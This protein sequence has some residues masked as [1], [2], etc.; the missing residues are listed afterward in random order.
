MN[1]KEGIEIN[2][3]NDRNEPNDTNDLKYHKATDMLGK[4]F[5]NF[6]FLILLPVSLSVITAVIVNIIAVGLGSGLSL[7][8]LFTLIAPIVGFF[9]LPSEKYRDKKIVLR[10]DIINK[11]HY[12]HYFLISAFSILYS[13]ILTIVF[14]DPLS[15]SLLHP[16]FSI[17]SLIFYFKSRDLPDKNWSIKDIRNRKIEQILVISGISLRSVIVI[18]LANFTNE[19][20]YLLIP[21]IFVLVLDILGYITCIFIFNKK[22]NNE[23]EFE[24]NTSEKLSEKTKS[25][26]VG[27]SIPA[28]QII[29]LA[30][31]GL[32]FSVLNDP[33]PNITLL[34]FLPIIGFTFAVKS[35][36]FLIKYY[37]EMPSD[38]NILNKSSKIT[39]LSSI[40]SSA[41]LI[42]SMGLFIFE[43]FPN[44]NYLFSHFYVV[45]ILVISY[46][47][48]KKEM[49]QRKFLT[50]FITFS[51]VLFISMITFV[52][53]IP[54]DFF[55]LN[56]LIF[57]VLL[58]LDIEFLKRLKILTNQK[59]DLILAILSYLIIYEIVLTIT[60]IFSGLAFSGFNVALKWEFAF[61]FESYTLALLIGSIVSGL[62]LYYSNYKMKTN[63]RFKR[64]FL[65]LHSLLIINIVGLITFTIDSPHLLSVLI[66]GIVTLL[67]STILFYVYQKIG[68]Y[69]FPDY[70][71]L[72][73]YSF[74]IQTVLIGTSI[75]STNLNL[76]SFIGSSLLLTGEIILDQFVR[77]KTDMG[78]SDEL[79]RSRMTKLSST[80]VLQVTLYLFALLSIDF[81]IDLDISIFITS[82]FSII[83][84]IITRRVIFTRKITQLYN[85]SNLSIQ[86]IFLSN[87]INST[88][89][90]LL[91]DSVSVIPPIVLFIP[92]LITASFYLV[93]I[94]TYGVKSGLIFRK[95]H[96]SITN[97]SYLLFFISISLLPSF[98]YQ[99]IF[100]SAVDIPFIIFSSF[101]T[102]IILSA[103]FYLD[104][105]TI[106]GLIDGPHEWISSAVLD[107]KINLNEGSKAS[108]NNNLLL[109]TLELLELDGEEQIRNPIDLLNSGTQISELMFRKSKT[110]KVLLHLSWVNSLVLLISTFL[111]FSDPGETLNLS[112]PVSISISMFLGSIFLIFLIINMVNS[113]IL[114]E[115]IGNRVL[116]INKVFLLFST[117]FSIFNLSFIYYNLPFELTVFISS[118]ISL[119]AFNLSNIRNTTRISISRSFIVVN[120]VLQM[121]SLSF[122]IINNLTPQGEL[123]PLV[124]TI[125]SYLTV[126]F[127]YSTKLGLIFGSLQN[128][129]TNFLFLTLYI[130]ISLIPSYFIPPT[131]NYSI[132]A[133]IFTFCATFN[134]LL[135][136]D[137]RIIHGLFSGP[138]MWVANAVV[139]NYII[140]NSS[141]KGVKNRKTLEKTLDKAVIEDEENAI[142]FL[143]GGGNP[144]SISFQTTKI[145]L[146]FFHLGW[147]SALIGIVFSIY[148][149]NLTVNAQNMLISL[150]FII[151]GIFVTSLFKNLANSLI[152]DE[153]IRKKAQTTIN[154]FLLFA[155]SMLGTSLFTPDPSLVD[156]T[157]V[158]S[159]F[160]SC[161]VLKGLMSSKSERFKLSDLYFLPF[162]FLQMIFVPIVLN[163]ILDFNIST[164]ENI[165]QNFV[166]YLPI[167]LILFG[168]ITFIL[169]RAMKEGYIYQKYSPQLANLTYFALFSTMSFIPTYVLQT[170][171]SWGVP[172]PPQPEGLFIPIYSLFTVLA[173]LSIFF[174]ID[175]RR[176]QALFNGPK[177]WMINALRQGKIDLESNI[178][179]EI[180]KEK[181]LNVLQ[182][183][184][185]PDNDE[186]EEKEQENRDKILSEILL[187]SED[188]SQIEFQE[189][190]THNIF[191]HIAWIS[192]ILSIVMFFILLGNFIEPLI[193]ISIPMLYFGLL[194]FTL[195]GNLEKSHTIGSKIKRKLTIYSYIYLILAVAFNIF[196]LSNYIM[197][198]NN[199]DQ[200]VNYSLSIEFAI[201]FVY[202]LFLVLKK[203]ITSLSPKIYYIIISSIWFILSLSSG[204]LIGNV[205]GYLIPIID[206]HLILRFTIITGAALIL[207]IKSIEY[208]KEYNQLILR[209]IN[210]EESFG[211]LDSLDENFIINSREMVEKGV[212]NPTTEFILAE[213]FP[214]F[215]TSIMQKRLFNL[216]YLIIPLIPFEVR[217]SFGFS[218]ESFM[219]YFGLL[220]AIYLVDNAYINKIAKKTS[221]K[222]IFGEWTIFQFLFAAHISSKIGLLLEIDLTGQVILT[223]LISSLSLQFMNYIISKAEIKLGIWNSIKNLVTQICITITS[224]LYL[225]YVYL[226][227]DL[228]TLNTVGIYELSA[229]FQFTPLLLIFIS[230]IFNWSYIRKFPKQIRFLRTF[231]FSYIPVLISFYLLRESSFLATTFIT[232]IGIG[233]LFYYYSLLPKLSIYNLVLTFTGFLYLNNFFVGPWNL[234]F[235][236]FGMTPYPNPNLV[237]YRIFLAL[238]LTFVSR[239]YIKKW[240]YT[241]LYQGYK[242]EYPKSRGIGLFGGIGRSIGFFF[243]VQVVVMI[244]WVFKIHIGMFTS[245]DIMEY[246][247]ANAI[248]GYALQF[249]VLFLS[250]YYFFRDYLS[251]N[252]D[253][254]YK[255]RFVLRICTILSLTTAFVVSVLI[256]DNFYRYALLPILVLL[257]RALVS[258]EKKYPYRGTNTISIT[259]SI[260]VFVFVFWTL[261]QFVIDPLIPSSLPIG[262]YFSAGISGWVF[263]NN[264]KYIDYKIRKIIIPAT[265][266]LSN[267]LFSVGFF[268]LIFPLMPIDFDGS[269]AFTFL[270]T[271][272]FGIFLSYVGIALYNRNVSKKVWLA[273]WPLWTILPIINFSLI[274]YSLIGI[275]EIMNL[276]LFGLTIDGSILIT[277]LIF[278]VLYFPVILYKFKNFYKYAFLVLWAEGIFLWTAITQQLV[279]NAGPFKDSPI[280][281]PLFIVGLAMISLL[282]LLYQLKQWKSVATVW[283]VIAIANSLFFSNFIPDQLIPDISIHLL[284]YGAFMMIFFY[285]PVMRERMEHEDRGL[286]VGFITMFA[287][288]AIIL[289][290]LYLLTFKDITIAICLSGI[291]T[292]I[293]MIGGK[294]IKFLRDKLNI[295]SVSIVALSTGVLIS[296][297]TFSL[298]IFEYQILTNLF[299]ISSGLATGFL[300]ILLSQSG[301]FITRRNWHKYHFIFGISTGIAI[302]SIF[303]S[304]YNLNLAFFI[305]FLLL[306]STLISYPAFK[307]KMP[308][309]IILPIPISIFTQQG[310][311]TAIRL[312]LGG[313][314]LPSDQIVALDFSL[315]IVSYCIMIGIT[316]KI[317][318]KLYEHSELKS[319]NVLRE[320]GILVENLDFLREMP[321]TKEVYLE[322]IEIKEQMKT[323]QKAFRSIEQVPRIFTKPEDLNRIYS[324]A[325]STSLFLSS[326][327]LSSLIPNGFILAPVLMLSISLSSFF[328]LNYNKNKEIFQNKS[329]IRLATIFSSNLFYISIN[330]GLSLISINLIGMAL[331]DDTLKIIL[332]Y[333]VVT[334]LIYLTLTLIDEKLKFYDTLSRA[335][336]ETVSWAAFTLFFA[337]FLTIYSFSVGFGNPFIFFIVTTLGGINFKRHLI[338]Y[339]ED[340]STSIAYKVDIDAIPMGDIESFKLDPSSESSQF[341][342]KIRPSPMVPP[343]QIKTDIQQPTETIPDLT[344]IQEG[345]DVKIEGDIKIDGATPRKSIDSIKDPAKNRFINSEE[346]QEYSYKLKLNGRKEAQI[347]KL[348]TAYFY[349]NGYIRQSLVLEMSYIISLALTALFSL[350]HLD[351]VWFSVPFDFSLM[352][353][354]F[355][356]ILTLTYNYSEFLKKEYRAKITMI[357]SGALLFSTLILPFF[358]FQ[359]FSV[360]LKLIDGNVPNFVN[361]FSLVAF[362]TLAVL[363]EILLIVRNFASTKDSSMEKSIISKTV[364]IIHPALLILV[365]FTISNFFSYDLELPLPLLFMSRITITSFILFFEIILDEFVLKWYD[366]YVRSKFSTISWFLCSIT[367]VVQ[368][369]I[370]VPNLENKISLS[371]GAI[372]LF[373]FMQFLTVWLS[374]KFEKE[375][376]LRAIQLGVNK[377]D[378]LESLNFLKYKMRKYSVLGS[379]LYT[380]V[381]FF[382][383]TSVYENIYSS[384]I[385]ALLF[386]PTKLLIVISFLCFIAISI[387]LLLTFFDGY[388]VKILEPI[389]RIKSLLTQW[390]ILSSY[391]LVFSLLFAIGGDPTSPLLLLSMAVLQ[392]YTLYLI[393][394][395]ILVKSKNREI[396]EFFTNKTDSVSEDTLKEAELLLGYSPDWKQQIGYNKERL[397]R[398]YLINFVLYSEPDRNRQLKR[399]NAVIGAFI[400]SIVAYSIAQIVYNVTNLPML[401]IV[402]GMVVLYAQSEINL[403]YLKSFNDRTNFN[404]NLLSWIGFSLCLSILPLFSWSWLEDPIYISL[405]MLYASLF[406]IIL[407]VTMFWTTSIVQKSKIQEPEYTLNW[408]RRL[409]ISLYFTFAFV[410]FSLISITGNFILATIIAGIVLY[411]ETVVE[412]YNPLIEKKVTQFISI[413]SILIILSAILTW[414]SRSGNSPF[415]FPSIMLGAGALYI[416]SEVN[417]RYTK[418]FSEKNNFLFNLG[419]WIIFSVLLSITPLF[420]WNPEPTWMA[421]TLNLFY[422]SGMFLILNIT[423]VWTLSIMKRGEIKE[424]DIIRSWEGRLRISLYFTIMFAIFSAVLIAGRF[425]IAFLSAGIVL[426]IETVIE[427]NNPLLEAK[428]RKLLRIISVVMIGISLITWELS[429]TTLKENIPL[430]FIVVSI[431]VSLLSILIVNP[432]NSKKWG[433]PTYWI[434][435][436]FEF[437]FLFDILGSLNPVGYNPL[438]SPIFT[439]LAVFFYPFIFEVKE[440]YQENRVLF[441]IL[442]A[443]VSDIIGIIV[444]MDIIPMTNNFIQAFSVSS[445]LSSAIWLF[446]VFY[447]KEQRSE[448]EF[449]YRFSYWLIIYIFINMVIYSFFPAETIW[450]SYSITLFCAPSLGFIRVF[451]GKYNLSIK[452][453][454]YFTIIA[455]ISSI[456]SIILMISYILKFLS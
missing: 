250:L 398:K 115:D 308:F 133:D 139:K 386:E 354:S 319:Q 312:I 420:Y 389:T 69:S 187:T 215:S 13:L 35:I 394:N 271:I 2:D 387:P 255:M 429:L 216:I 184:I 43:L 10:E 37:L 88:V 238:G 402:I 353:F 29:A 111:F 23:E 318:T 123:L 240:G 191:Y 296:R 186:T 167:P 92:A 452:W 136:L 61:K 51:S 227:S 450:Y 20:N 370:V 299:S 291:T 303:Q 161:M 156:L 125:S 185:S 154:L 85:I 413:G 68:I 348:K 192:N 138:K 106:D 424:I 66:P 443:I 385:P 406:M 397:R 371:I 181:L 67:L 210:L 252:A 304:L 8:V 266:L 104:R 229:L 55:V 259:K 286:V 130:T 337:S 58:Y 362:T 134:I 24:E 5:W 248:V 437:G 280:L 165:Y 169:T 219:L 267:V 245:N 166:A 246:E 199:V 128:I 177:Y 70:I 344:E 269:T 137:H 249:F 396:S 212:S 101:T 146:L 272:D 135:Y 30:T 401:S 374:F 326:Y 153:T 28:V 409:R 377:E 141:S 407:N 204:A 183:Q 241:D 264:L 47:E 242:E 172:I 221:G 427:N 282:P 57:S 228:N 277:L 261:Y 170:L 75:I 347:E 196:A 211:D 433:R 78:V 220:F 71:R 316:F 144:E 171:N 419:T 321:E 294:A 444:L 368:L 36:H 410:I 315:W 126:I 335:L 89:N 124:L 91:G 86:L 16:I 112:F 97:L 207:S 72:I 352:F 391:L 392:Y 343:F 18:I 226:S 140:L 328:V 426:I 201:L 405:N 239:F 224:L 33:I 62:K 193:S 63:P 285:N 442:G 237:T 189:L 281:S 99:V 256:Y 79:I 305:G 52:I 109:K 265:I 117:I 1:E 310:L 120:L 158:I 373:T 65:S 145:Q 416:Q 45:V 182:I 357:T 113:K 95:I 260:L 21:I 274:N 268:M 15:I 54:Q 378:Q 345:K 350:T 257:Y 44:S 309:W 297:I 349:V 87:V 254:S 436:S 155:F 351:K 48:F 77:R 425:D 129:I 393:T 380:L 404:F 232:I 9:I 236:M 175:G 14:T 329:F 162:L 42:S 302:S 379:F 200:F 376:I 96:V 314:G 105:K 148:L 440:Y 324:I 83:I 147:I 300:L 438:F 98:I 25:E 375:K 11:R 372:L 451:E 93:A 190:K 206:E 119:V 152:I 342:T 50:Y 208:F 84:P 369:F 114:K 157:I 441:L 116:E 34:I 421:Q 412:Y 422:I 195:I 179:G 323:A 159:S 27:I 163:P 367:A 284:V 276:N 289:N 205:L 253:L 341:E 313:F 364:S 197:E 423:M 218:V 332:N 174:I 295:I 325:L 288:I 74:Q 408:N 17:L 388:S 448:K 383:A 38:Q 41:F 222:A 32:W 359:Q 455:I 293:L 415:I 49:L 358:V 287:G 176:S 306:F 234:F 173:S 363:L 168:Y 230:I 311:S 273:G 333:S 132:S 283:G 360:P 251:E 12:G 102:T 338:Q 449:F 3:R 428:T 149:L 430:G 4:F 275:N 235:P 334:F 339:T 307:V 355:S 331:L 432:F 110:N 439:G 122:L 399:I 384:L 431:S 103:I 80:L 356:L 340:Y 447:R 390:L 233:V 290:G 225:S 279:N 395:L 435:M 160:I 446:R 26:I 108:K 7:A 6:L 22:I 336:L 223:L 53:P 418:S 203:K 414:E 142:T 217:M 244:C 94:F 46:F 403:R 188:P 381:G 456:V 60:E 214:I 330:F 118:M 417:L 150:N 127:I 213:Q 445:L 73:L 198:R 82:I 270:I 262:L 39:K 202:V 131:E 64:I 454:F 231:L 298:N 258:T 107:K 400:Y 178:I 31:L 317:V 365:A 434:L 90:N 164:P 453:R 59:T 243:I 382:V 327:V 278:T 292:G 121:I 76:S 320:M 366:K 40:L 180:N 81:K 247:D 143:E 411:M 346:Q 361:M 301:S 322:T 263:A 151:S 56:I 209:E 100:P 19:I 194:A